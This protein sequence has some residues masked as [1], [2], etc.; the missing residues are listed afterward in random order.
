L[1]EYLAQTS[2]TA[3]VTL[4]GICGRVVETFNGTETLLCLIGR[5]NFV[6]EKQACQLA[7]VNMADMNNDSDSAKR[8]LKAFLTRR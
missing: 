4:S 1:H 3:E 5:A 6:F 8:C 7:V 2:Q